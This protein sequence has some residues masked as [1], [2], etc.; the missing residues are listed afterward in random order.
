MKLKK[1]DKNAF[2]ISIHF[3]INNLQ[4]IQFTLKIKIIKEDFALA[5]NQNLAI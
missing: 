4:A 5:D 2:N 1:E 3:K